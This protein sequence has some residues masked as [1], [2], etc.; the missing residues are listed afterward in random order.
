MVYRCKKC[1]STNIQVRAWVGANDNAIHD[2]CDE[3]GLSNQCWCENCQEITTW[4][5]KEND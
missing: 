2:W 5:G 4:V 1:G 3:D